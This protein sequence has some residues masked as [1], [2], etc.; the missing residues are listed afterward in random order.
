M[1]FGW[2]GIGVECDEGVFGAGFLEGVVEGEETG[3][4]FGVSD[5]CCPDCF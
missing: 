5:E 3:E 2:E 4:V 1:P